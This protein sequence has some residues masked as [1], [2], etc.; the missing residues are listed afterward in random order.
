MNLHKTR[1]HRVIA[2]AILVLTALGLQL[3]DSP[4]QLIIDIFYLM[5]WF[6]AGVDV[7]LQ[8]WVNL[9]SKYLF[10]EHF[11]MSIATIGAIF[12]GEYM[13]AAMVM[14]LYQIGEILQDRA[15]DR[16]RKSVA[17]LMD[18]AAPVA[19]R[20]DGGRRRAID[21]EE[22]AIG[23]LLEVPSGEKIPVDG[24]VEEGESAIDRSALTGES[25]PVQVVAG[26]RVLSGSINGNGRLLIRAENTAEDSTAM[27][28]IRLLEEATENQ[29]RTES[30]IS[31]FAR[32]YT[33]IVVLL[34][35]FIGL[36]LPVLL[37][38]SLSKDWMVRGLSFL[39][40][41]CPCAFVISV[42]MAFVA[43]L[44]IGSKMGI[45]VKGGSVFEDLVKIDSLAMD[46]TG[47]LT[48]GKFKLIDSRGMPGV[49]R[50][51]M[52]RL[53]VSIERGS[54]HPIALAL[55]ETLEGRLPEGDS[56]SMIRI[57]SLGGR[58]MLAEEEEGRYILGSRSLMEE[59][60]FGEVVDENTDQDTVA[61]VIHLAMIEPERR[62]F[63]YYLIR[64]EIKEGAVDDLRALRQ[65]GL[66]NLVILTGDNELVAGEVARRLGVDDYRSRLLPQDK[67]AWVQDRQENS[68]VAF[69]GD[70]L[71]DAPVLAASRVGIAMGGIGSDAAIEA[72][73]VVLMKD[74]LRSLSILWTLAGKTMGIAR[75]NIILSIGIKTVF[76]ALTGLGL[77]PMWMAVFG[78]VGVTLLAVANCFRLYGLPSRLFPSESREMA[79]GGPSVQAE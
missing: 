37:T 3:T 76:L 67:L 54:G 41:S 65:S 45:L 1:N 14:V 63:G 57:E 55:L 8:A 66:R 32:V 60:G 36:I 10:A 16:S 74:D 71:N 25:I 52:D 56:L 27:R 15:V 7:V 47:T 64:D 39:V 35:A 2:S 42:P 38:G 62:Y 59:Y 19:Y 20:L 72:A 53:T 43:G 30:L 79:S 73:D 50:A 58:G 40:I 17:D 5:A 6:M 51:E 48:E 77:L 9:K 31:R 24:L 70:G 44:G 61:T 13:E 68:P 11:L 22:I 23:D 34:A 46:K 4:Y 21:P 18:I 28:I 33:P 49:D 78:D 26:D 12:L 75:Q 29:A 69:V